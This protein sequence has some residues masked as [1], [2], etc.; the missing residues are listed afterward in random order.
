ML[1]TIAVD[2]DGV[3]CEYHGWR[4]RDHFGVIVRGISQFLQSLLDRGYEVIIHSVRCSTL[5]GAQRVRG[6][7]D[8]HQVPYTDIW[9]QTG[10]PLA[11]AYVDDRAVHIS[12]NPNLSDFHI[13][14][15]DIDKAYYA[16]R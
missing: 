6:W 2:F 8:E 3:I 7:L 15:N 16:A 11:F 5:T 10:K 1:K 13:A 4:G 14:I 9:C 12:M